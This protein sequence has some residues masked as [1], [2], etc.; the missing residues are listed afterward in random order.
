MPCNKVKS[1]VVY[2]CV[3]CVF[4]WGDLYYFW[5]FFLNVHFLWQALIRSHTPV[6]KQNKT[7]KQHLRQ[8]VK[9]TESSPNVPCTGGRTGPDLEQQS[10]SWLLTVYLNHTCSWTLCLRINYAVHFLCVLFTQCEG[11]RV[12]LA[13]GL[14][15]PPCCP[16]V[17]PRVGTPDQQQQHL[18]TCQ[19]CRD[20][21]GGPSNLSDCDACWPWETPVG[22]HF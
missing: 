13:T 19:K 12:I 21:G 11:G 5:N 1:C 17:V 8:G 15:H 7:K 16:A 14:F 10:L 4:F 6:K 20:F 3:V 2:V 9:L 22:A 18:G